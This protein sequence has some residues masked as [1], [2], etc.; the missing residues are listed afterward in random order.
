MRSSGGVV[1]VV[2]QHG[3]RCGLKPIPRLYSLTR[4]IAMDSH[5]HNTAIIVPLAHHP[6]R[7]SLSHHI[8]L[9][10]LCNAAPVDTQTV[11]GTETWFNICFN[12]C[13]LLFALFCESTNGVHWISSTTCVNACTLY[14]CTFGM[15]SPITR[16]T[17]YLVFKSSQP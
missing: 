9:L 12:I 3:S 10:M 2:S 4:Y 7:E 14:T 5:A 6:L 17:L 16:K 1:V 15:A 13:I 11:K 8:Y